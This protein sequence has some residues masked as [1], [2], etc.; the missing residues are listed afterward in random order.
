M[1]NSEAIRTK[2]L[3]MAVADQK[4][5]YKMTKLAASFEPDKLPQLLDFVNDAFIMELLPNLTR[6]LFFAEQPDLYS[7]HALLKANEIVAQLKGYHAEV[8]RATNG[9]KGE[10]NGSDVSAP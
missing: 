2:S 7:K 10:N 9:G 6:Y 5:I 1:R 8:L 4:V 3:E